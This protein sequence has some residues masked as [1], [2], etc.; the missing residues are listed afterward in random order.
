MDPVSQ[1]VRDYL[2]GADEREV[3]RILPYR[4]AEALRLDRFRDWAQGEPLPENEHL[5]VRARLGSMARGGETLVTDA[6]LTEEGA[7]ALAAAMAG[8]PF[9]TQIRGL[10]EPVSG[11]R[12]QSGP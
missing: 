12:L 5:E 11:Y 8:E 7:R 2:L 6:V 4:A 3:F 1:S 10:E 9:T